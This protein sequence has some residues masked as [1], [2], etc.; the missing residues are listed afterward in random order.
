MISTPSNFGPE[1]LEKNK[2][3]TLIPLIPSSCYKGVAHRQLVL[4]IYLLFFLARFTMAHR[5]VWR[6][7][8]FCR[9]NWKNQRI[10]LFFFFFETNETHL[11]KADWMEE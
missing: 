9:M 3:D 7:A 10:V 11:A 6:T 5:I 4:F 1:H 2:V 8:G